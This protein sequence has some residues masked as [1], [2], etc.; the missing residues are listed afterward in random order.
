MCFSFISFIFRFFLV[1]YNNARKALV[2]AEEE[3]NIDSNVSDCEVPR[4]K[5]R[6]IRF[7]SDDSDND[8]PPKRCQTM[9]V[10]DSEDDLNQENA[11]SVLRDKVQSILKNVSSCKRKPFSEQ[12]LNRVVGEQNKNDYTILKK[13]NSDNNR[14]KCIVVETTAEGNVNRKYHYQH[15]VENE[16]SLFQERNTTFSGKA[17]KHRSAENAHAHDGLGKNSYDN[18]ITNDRKILSKA[19]IRFVDYSLYQCCGSR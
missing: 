9:A 12:F 18:P 1:T 8:V 17:T 6:P 4:K 3:T 5:K 10:S 16:K 15:L 2:K 7:E 13:I 11:K 19:L 14:T